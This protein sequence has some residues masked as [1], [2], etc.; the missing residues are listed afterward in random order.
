M[1][2]REDEYRS[3]LHMTEVAEDGKAEIFKHL[4]KLDLWKEKQND[5]TFTESWTREN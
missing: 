4:E 1:D 2:R 5:S 3:L